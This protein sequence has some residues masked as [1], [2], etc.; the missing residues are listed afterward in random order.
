MDPLPP[1]NVVDLVQNNPARYLMFMSFQSGHDFASVV[2]AAHASGAQVFMDGQVAGDANISNSR[3]AAALR[4]VD[5]FALNQKEA[6]QLTREDNVEAALEHLAQYTSTV[7]IKLGANGVIAQSQG[8]RVHVQG[9]LTDVVDTTGAGDNF[10]CG[11]LYGLLHK[12]SLEDCLR[13]GNFCGSRSTTMQGGW[14][15]SPT[16]DQLEAY[17]QTSRE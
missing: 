5:I 14:D 16:A 4:S 15:T 10:D 13:C 8:R 2:D 3:T 11:F 12:Y 7:I 6:L 1:M 9:I 17:L